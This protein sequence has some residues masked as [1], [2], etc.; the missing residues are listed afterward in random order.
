MAALADALD[1][2]CVG[3]H[4]A[5]SRPILCSYGVPRLHAWLILGPV[6]YSWMLFVEA[7]RPHGPLTADAT[8]A[9]TESPESQ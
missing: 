6:G 9:I 3:P 4:A 2:G 1:L 5:N 8:D 7:H